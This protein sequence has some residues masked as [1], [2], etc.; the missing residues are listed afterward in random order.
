M[1]S[2]AIDQI[3]TINL[4]CTKMF[5]TKDKIFEGSIAWISNVREP[6]WRAVVLGVR[7]EAIFVFELL[8]QLKYLHK[9]PRHACV[10]TNHYQIVDS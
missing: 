7:Q 5:R 4:R 2:E 3:I 9:S 10:L 8:P 1:S 6:N